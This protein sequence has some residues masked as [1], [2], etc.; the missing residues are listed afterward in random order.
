MTDHLYQRIQLGNNIEEVCIRTTH[1]NDPSSYHVL[2]DDIQDVFQNAQRFK[3]NGHPVPFLV[4]PNG[5]RIK[6]LRIAFYPNDILEVITGP[7]QSTAFVLSPTNRKLDI[8]SSQHL[9][10]SST[11]LLQSFNSSRAA[12]ETEQVEKIKSELALNLRSIEKHTAVSNENSQ[13]MKNM[14]MKIKN[15]LLEAKEKNDRIC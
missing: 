11:N 2:L 5:E 1:D 15:L 3:R 6:P 12:G 10:S 8:Q 9:L 4:S 7:S 14:Q 13:E